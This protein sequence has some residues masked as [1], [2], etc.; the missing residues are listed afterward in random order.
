MKL[1]KLELKDA[2]QM[3][4]WMHD[5]DVIKN[6]QADFLSKTLKDCQEFIVSSWANYTFV[7]PYEL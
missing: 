3:L 7:Y 1:R 6:L 4:E 2:S 5:E